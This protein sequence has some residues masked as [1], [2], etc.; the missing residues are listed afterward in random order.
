[1]QK[2]IKLGPVFIAIACIG[3]FLTTFILAL[4]YKNYNHLTMVMS[5]LGSLNSPV[6]IWISIFGVFY[7]ILFI[8]FGYSFYAVF[9]N[10]K[11]GKIIGYLF[12]ANGI[13]AGILAGIFPMNPNTL[14]GQIHNIAAGS[15]FFAIAFIPIIALKLFNNKN[16]RNLQK[17]LVI[18]QI[19]GL[20]FFGLFIMA[21]DALSGNTIFQYAGL[22]QRV[23]LLNYYIVFMVLALE[24][25]NTSNAGVA[26]AGTMIKR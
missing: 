8:L 1:M 7:G 10:K 16:H 25:Y 18:S 3:D 5:E 14:S 17:F 9:K 24:L 11:S 4:F 23:F 20:S 26:H 21:E 12:A 15:G 22:W 6:A 13:G 19:L 2:I